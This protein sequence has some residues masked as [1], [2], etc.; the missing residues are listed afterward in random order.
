MVTAPVIRVL[1]DRT[2]VDDFR[3]LVCH[4]T[5]QCS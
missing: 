3:L 1:G 4:G 5:S 2:E